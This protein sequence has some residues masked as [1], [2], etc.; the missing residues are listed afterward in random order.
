[1][2]YVRY[3]YTMTKSMRFQAIKR[4]LFPAPPVYV[5]TETDLPRKQKIL[6]FLPHSDDGRYFGCSLYWLNKDNDVRI[7]IL[8]PGNHGVDG[9]MPEEE[10]INIRWCEAKAWA[11]KLEYDENQVINFRADRTYN[12]GRIFREEQKRLQ[13]MIFTE[14]PTVVFIPPISDTAQ[15]MNYFTRKM[16]IRSL[17]NWMNYSY[18]KRPREKRTVYI[19]EYPTNHVPFL[20][21]SDR[22]FIVFF[23]NPTLAN[24][25]HEANKMHMSQASSFFDFNARVVEAMQAVSD[26]DTLH[27]ISNRR[28]RFAESLSGIKVDPHTSRGEHFAVTRLTVQEKPQRILEERLIFPLSDDDLKKWFDG[29]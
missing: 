8:S 18:Q 23:T 13:E 7:I 10:K 27:H 14:K 4:L 28:R 22:N 9:D 24:V 19:M 1:V 12:S 2:Q 21:P 15:P 6:V 11:K 29:R 5:H 20:P 17:L 3:H 16:V 26:A 25:K